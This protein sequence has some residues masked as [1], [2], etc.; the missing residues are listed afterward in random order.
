MNPPMNIQLGLSAALLLAAAA[1]A[2]RPGADTLSFRVRD[3]TTLARKF[4]SRQEISQDEAE[5]LMNGQPFPSGTEGGMTAIQTQTLEISDEF[6][7]LERHVP[8]NLRRTFSKI[9]SSGEQTTQH[10]MDSGAQTDTREARSELEGKTI[11]FEWDEAKQAFGKSFDPQGPDEGLLAGLTEDLDFRQLLPEKPDVSADD[12][13]SIEVGAVQSLLLPGGDLRLKPV[14]GPEA[15]GIAD[16]DVLGSDPAEAF[17]G[18]VGEVHGTY[19][20]SRE[21]AGVHCGVIALDFKISVTRDLS[22]KLPKA[23]SSDSEMRIVRVE[24]FLALEGDGELLWDLGAGHAR[25]FTMSAKIKNQMD[26]AMKIPQGGKD[27][28]ITRK[29]QMSGSYELKATVAKL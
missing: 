29:M 13:W 8:R 4:E 21:V 1:T 23:G 22:D 14:E 7:T 28:D 25:S 20:G 9:E 6:V 5:I 12:T 17:T 26:V 19:K 24:T 10:P 11:A 16:L 27:L 3:G 2:V 15:E 18:M